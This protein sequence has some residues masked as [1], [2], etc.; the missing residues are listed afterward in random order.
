MKLFGISAAALATGAVLRKRPLDTVLA[1]VVI[2]GT[3]HL[4]NLVDV[5]PGRA[6]GAVA[7]L[8][9][10]GLLHDGAAGELSP[11]GRPPRRPSSPT[12]SANV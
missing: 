10:L 4:V 8:G 9:T 5:R 3:A 7:V 6:A 2:A 12:T 1:A 11:P